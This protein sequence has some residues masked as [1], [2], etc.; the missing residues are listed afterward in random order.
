[1]DHSHV[2]SLA[3]KHAG[4]DGQIINETSRPL[5]DMVMIARLKKQKLRIKE[6]LSS[7]ELRSA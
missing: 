7:F 2:A 3:A 5:P 4:I 6:E 1:M